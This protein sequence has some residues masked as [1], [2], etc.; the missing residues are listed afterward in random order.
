MTT[1]QGKMQADGFPS[2]PLS[3][4]NVQETGGEEEGGVTKISLDPLCNVCILENA[5]CPSCEGRAVVSASH[6]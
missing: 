6:A 4:A 1:L 5:C 2:F 3:Q